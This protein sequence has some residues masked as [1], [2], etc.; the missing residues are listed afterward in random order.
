LTYTLKSKPSQGNYP[1]KGQKTQEEIILCI[2][3]V[4]Y[5]QL[6]KVEDKVSMSINKDVD[7]DFLI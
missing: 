5:R 3:E 7:L 1:W 6:Y 2:E 4:H